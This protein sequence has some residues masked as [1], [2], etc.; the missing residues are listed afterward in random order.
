MKN[1]STLMYVLAITFLIVDGAYL[2]WSLLAHNFELIG[3]ITMGLSGLLCLFIA[4]YFARS[5]VG[6]AAW[7]EDRP[8]AEIDDG[9]PEIGH[10]SPQ[11][12]WPVLLAGSASLL[13]LGVA[14]SAWLAFLAVPF[15]LICVV[16]W[17]YEYYRGYFAR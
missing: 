4:F 2:T 3:L 6:S 10:F 14:I 1:T 17:V 7:P 11:S 16:G 9:D 5:A 15:L 13:I 12:W 8:N